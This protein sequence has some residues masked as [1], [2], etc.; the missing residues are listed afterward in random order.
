MLSDLHGIIPDGSKAKVRLQNQVQDDLQNINVNNT[1]NRKECISILFCHN[2][3]LSTY[4]LLSPWCR[5]GHQEG[6]CSAPS[7]RRMSALI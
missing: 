6:T 1:V 3:G 2:K 4:S 5:S 7:Y